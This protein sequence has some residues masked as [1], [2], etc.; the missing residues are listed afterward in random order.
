LLRLRQPCRRCPRQSPPAI[1]GFPLP[2]A[3]QHVRLKESVTSR[4]S[5]VWGRD[6]G[7]AN[8]VGTFVKLSAG[9]GSREGDFRGQLCPPRRFPINHPGGHDGSPSALP[10]SVG[11]GGPISP[12]ARGICDEEIPHGK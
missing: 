12:E 9:E 4:P 6:L 7:A 11:A 8:P 3:W 5:H 10:P 1:P 2:F